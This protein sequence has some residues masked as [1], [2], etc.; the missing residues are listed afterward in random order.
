MTNT[1][2]ETTLRQR[3]AKLEEALRPFAAEARDWLDTV[4][5]DERPEIGR[6]YETTGTECAKF[7]FGDLRLAASL[8][9][10]RAGETKTAIDE[11]F[12][13]GAIENGRAFMN[14]IEQH[15]DFEG[16]AGPLRN[17]YEWQEL[18]RCFDHLAAWALPHASSIPTP[19]EASDDLVEQVARII[20][21]GSWS[22]M[23][24]EKER[25][26][27]KY[28]GENIGY[29]E[30]QFRHKES[31]AKASA[32]LTIVLSEP[33]G[34]TNEN[35][36]KYVDS[37]GDRLFYPG[38]K[39]GASIALYRT[40]ADRGAL[41]MPAPAV[42]EGKLREIRERHDYCTH[43]ATKTEWEDEHAWKAHADRAALLE[44]LDALT[45]GDRDAE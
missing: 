12:P 7:T 18:R 3:I 26:L 24:A 21:P 30:D 28:K 8:L 16:E 31:M 14:R 34:Y 5:N 37:G 41:R 2:M 10:G 29:P 39:S 22:V 44:M 27:R 35:Q 9:E 45:K 23:D 25:F 40:H 11:D 38:D 6:S 15:Y 20:D 4:P 33:V 32:I 43:V 13:M 19:P 1:N 42:D 36:L 17:C